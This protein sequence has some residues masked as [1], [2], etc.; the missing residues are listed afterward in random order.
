MI[1]T[2]P[3]AKASIFL[4]VVLTCLGRG[5]SEEVASETQGWLF[6]ADTDHPWNI[7]YETL[8]MEERTKLLSEEDRSKAVG[9]LDLVLGSDPTEHSAVQRVVMQRAAWATFDFLVGHDETSGPMGREIRHRL[10]RLIALTALTEQEIARLPSNYTTRA[11]GDEN[12]RRPEYDLSLPS[13]LLEPNGEWIQ[14]VYR[15][16]RRIAL[17]HE[18]SHGGRSEFL[19]FMRFPEGRSGGE[20]YLKRFN[21]YA[22]IEARR[23]GGI[24][25]RSTSHPELIPRVPTFPDNVGAI[26]LERMLVVSNSGKPTST[27]IIKSLAYIDCSSTDGADT[28]ASHKLRSAVLEISVDRLLD[29]DSV[30]SLRRLSEDE[31]FFGE[32][33]FPQGLRECILCHGNTKDGLISLTGSA[34]EMI[35]PK[36]RSVEILRNGEATWTP[37]WKSKRYDFGVLQGMLESE[38]ESNLTKRGGT[39]PKEI[40]SP[41]GNWP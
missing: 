36:N 28:R 41:A 18:L 11:L 33:L 3:I 17:T 6:D 24:A 2:I 34:P 39:S 4:C 13:D 30:I 27:P 37:K 9:I 14:V 19:L 31:P 26:L 23:Y 40:F 38:I 5:W 25:D 32:R 16:I 35:R 12:K 22:T 21:D 1:P 7:A 15:G 8:R 10:A 29:S 20:A